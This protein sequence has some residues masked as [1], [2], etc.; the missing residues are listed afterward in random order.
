MTFN[1]DILYDAPIA[2]I[3]Q[4]D[5]MIRQGQQ[6]RLKSRH[7]RARDVPS[8]SSLVSRLLQ[9]TQCYQACKRDKLQYIQAF[10]DKGTN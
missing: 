7:Y 6:E 9:Q 4:S 1:F 2:S 8:L 10:S 3:P 5:H